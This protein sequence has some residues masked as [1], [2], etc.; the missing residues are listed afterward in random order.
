[1]PFYTLDG[2]RTARITAIVT[3]DLGFFRSGARLRATSGFDAAKVDAAAVAT[4]CGRD[5]RVCASTKSGDG[6]NA[7]IF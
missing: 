6:S 7:L 4:P 5:R 2:L 1:M 3:Y